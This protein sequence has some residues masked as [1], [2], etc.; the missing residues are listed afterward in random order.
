LDKSLKL[1]ECWLPNISWWNTRCQRQCP[2]ASFDERDRA[3][4]IPVWALGH[5][6]AWTVSCLRPKL[7]RAAQAVF[8]SRCLIQILSKPRA[9]AGPS[10]ISATTIP[11]RLTERRRV[12]FHSTCNWVFNLGGDELTFALI[13]VSSDRMADS[14][15]L[16]CAETYHYRRDLD[17]P[18]QQE[19]SK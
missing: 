8:D 2:M 14:V 7:R 17:T 9:L 12:F 18:A 13:L 6:A 15:A 3:E 4:L 11:L 16:A 10:R 5:M 1:A 19:R